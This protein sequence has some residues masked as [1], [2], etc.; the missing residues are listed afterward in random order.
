MLPP[1]G[2]ACR[3][4][5]GQT[6]TETAVLVGVLAVA[7]IVA[8]LFFRFE[9]EGAFQADSD[10]ASNVFKPPTPTCDSNYSGACIPAFPPDVDCSDLAALGITTFFV[11][12]ADPHHLDPDGDG[13][14]CN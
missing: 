2:S 10:A 9:S 6:T 7:L 4:E 5:S 13:V 12:G 1:P 3:D 11:S 14:G 8:I